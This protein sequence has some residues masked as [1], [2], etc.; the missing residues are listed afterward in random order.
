MGKLRVEIVTPVHN[1]REIT[2]Q[3]LRSLARIDS[4][5]L[6]IHTIVVD[7]GSTDGTAEAI[8]EQFPEVEIVFGDGNLWYTAATNRGFEA[9]LKHDPD[10]VLAINDDAVFDEKFLQYLIETAERYA[11]AVVG[12]LLILWDTP[13][14]IFQIAPVWK[15]LEGGWFH[16]IQQTVWTI[17]Q[18]AWQVDLIV[19]NCVLYPA[20]A[21]REVGLMNEK[22][23]PN[24]GDAEHT[25]RMRRNGWRL[26]IEPRAR[27]FCQ[28]NNIPPSISQM[29]W[30]KKADA[31]WFDM[32]NTHNLRRRLN[33][34]LDGAP[35]KLT[36]AAAFLI[37]M[38]RVFLKKNTEKIS[39]RNSQPEP[40][41]SEVF[42]ESVVKD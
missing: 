21:L 9:A 35:N 3:C 38:T 19:G 42:A 2:L 36:G 7:D 23:F 29:S 15:T 5:G 18:K 22:R 32:K 39:A 34:N 37:F 11:P 8:R 40:P 14:K 4:A 16:W 20:K 6:D 24:Y 10:Y 26:L 33:A 30:R 12:G 17:P 31:L 1:R 27:V 13:H 25:P 41:L 28:P